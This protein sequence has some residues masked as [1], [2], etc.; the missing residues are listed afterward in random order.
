MPT[1][2]PIRRVAALVLGAATLTGCSPGHTPGT[3]GVDAYRAPPNLRVDRQEL[4]RVV[5]QLPPSSPQR[6]ILLDGTVTREELANAWTGLRTCL[7]T[8]GLKVTGPFMNPITNTEY[9]YTYDSRDGAA[10][11]AEDDEVHRCEQTYWNPVAQVYAANTPQRMSASLATFM[12]DCMTAALHT[13][14]RAST[15]DGLVRDRSG[16]VDDAR[17]ARANECLDRGMPRLFP[18]LPFFPRP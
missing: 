17:L 7:T 13:R 5:D 15:F 3:S 16:A 4:A 12:A 6:A 18:Q 1:R 10:G 2:S 9:L 11:A 8:H 14:V